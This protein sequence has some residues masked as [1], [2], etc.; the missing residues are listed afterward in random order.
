MITTKAL[1]YRSPAQFWLILLTL[2]ALMGALLLGA[3]QPP[4]RSFL[5]QAG[6]S[7]LA[8]T[9]VM[10]VGGQVTSDLSIINGVGALLTDAEL[11]ALR[12]NP[13]VVAI[14]PNYTVELVGQEGPETPETDIVNGTAPAMAAQERV[15]KGAQWPSTDYPDVTG[16]DLAWSEGVTGDGVTVA[17]LDTGVGLH[18]GIFVDAD[19]S[20]R[21]RVLAW[22][23]FV[24][25]VRLPFDL[26]GHGTHVAGVIANSQTGKDGEWNG[27][28]PNVSLVVGR[29]L[30]R[31]GQGT[32]EDVIK[33]IDWVV[34][35]ANRY[36]IRV[37]NLSLVSTASSPY[38]ADP[39]NQAVT[40]AWAKGIVVVVAAGNGG[41][42]P[43][44]VGVPG[45]NP[46]VI[47]AGAFTDAYTPSDWS[48]D[49]L[50]PFSS[51]GPTL[52]GFV[53][54]DVLS[55]GAHI[56][57]TML[58][59]AYLA[60]SGGA[61][62]VSTTYYAIAGT[63]QAAAVTSGTVALMLEQSPR[64]TPDQVKYRLMVTA[65]PWVD[66]AHQD[67]LYSIW[68]QGAGRL[69]AYD[70]VFAETTESANAGMKINADLKGKVHYE[71]YTTYDPETGTF[72]LRGDYGTWGSGYGVWSG[73]YGVWSGGY[74][75]WSG[76]YGVWS[77]GYGVWSG[78]YGV[79]S[80]GYG[81]WSGGYGVWS[82]GYGVWSG[83]Y[84]VWSGSEPWADAPLADPAFVASF[85]NG[86]SPDPLSSSA[87]TGVW[88]HSED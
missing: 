67:A 66:S 88:V 59:N 68:Q 75:V 56:V 23:D 44:T 14:T 42:E 61:E 35:N 69:N 77:G 17:I 47:T 36:N 28:A 48:D 12:T 29:V 9:L 53:K 22:K 63:S 85:L 45:N 30:D 50:V 87:S 1:H 41:P 26:N 32:Y 3:G 58:P 71:G 74:G 33:G 31:F 5:V 25:G 60:R 15:Y 19:G 62:K 27:M 80:G 20:L 37:L 51:A 18:P 34:K 73:G 10:D 40:Q 4:V 78:G 86:E 13:A 8:S 83:G 6:S 76:G 84:G 24:D 79:W 49:Y 82:G 52:D 39:L 7:D 21:D 55:P 57:S 38:W 46:Y 70:A 2:L 81:V 72:K 64:M 65:M 43:M 16:A 11:L 54:P